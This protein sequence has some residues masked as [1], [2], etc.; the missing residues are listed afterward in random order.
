MIKLIASDLDGTL[1][2][3]GDKSL[4]EDVRTAVLS[5]LASGKD[6]AVISGRDVL[7]LKALFSFAGNKPYFVGCNG[8]VCV[9]D[10]KVLYSRPVPDVSVIKA[11]KYAKVGGRNVVFCAADTVYVY[12]TDGFKKNVSSL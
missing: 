3:R 11:L 2:R 4:S 10:G 9:K 12:G 5:A 7:S 1:L 8:S 6:F